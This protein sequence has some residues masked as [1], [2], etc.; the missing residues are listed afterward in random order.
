MNDAAELEQAKKVAE[1][2][3]DRAKIELEREQIEAERKKLRRWWAP[4]LNV[5]AITAVLG[6]AAPFTTAVHGYFEKQR[7]LALEGQKQANAIALEKEKQSEQIRGSY[8]DRLKDPT[9]LQLILRFIAA[10]GPESMREWAGKELGYVDKQVVN[11][12]AD[13]SEKSKTAKNAEELAQ[14]AEQANMKAIA[15]GKPPPK[16]AAQIALLKEE[17]LRREKEKADAEAKLHPSAAAPPPAFS[18]VQQSFVPTKVYVKARCVPGTI[19]TLK[20]VP[21]AGW[22]YGGA[23]EKSPPA[24][25]VPSTATRVDWDLDGYDCQCKVMAPKA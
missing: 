17:A 15:D 3:R 2:E 13:V 18:P 19:Q 12:L 22:E 10:A 25:S 5:A 14:Q 8:L 21:G 11:L 7:E 24:V 6:I 1:I 4:G 23:C 20:N 9:E 16:S